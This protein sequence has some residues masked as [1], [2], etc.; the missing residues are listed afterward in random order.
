VLAVEKG[1]E[2]RVATI[3][4]YSTALIRSVGFPS[5]LV[6]FALDTGNANPICIDKQT[7]EIVYWLHDEPQSR[8]RPVADSLDAFLAGLRP[9][10]F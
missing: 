7:N 2:R 10:P 9:S 8:T 3:A 1:S 6:P 4:E 5:T